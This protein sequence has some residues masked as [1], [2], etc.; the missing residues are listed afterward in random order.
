MTSKSNVIFWNKIT[1]LFNLNFLFVFLNAFFLNNK[2]TTKA[3]N[4]TKPLSA[5]ITTKQS[6]QN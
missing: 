3:S 6:E 1:T 4:D 5:F 2:T